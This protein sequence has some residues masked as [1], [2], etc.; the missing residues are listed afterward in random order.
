[1]PFIHSRK[2]QSA[3]D[4]FPVGSIATASNGA[5]VR[6]VGHTLEDDVCFTAVV[7]LDP[8]MA[9][10]PNSRISGTEESPIHE[11]STFTRRAV[12]MNSD[13]W[14]ESTWVVCPGLSK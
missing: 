3:H 10:S 12:G 9:P 8:T 13:Y 11:H 5:L 14:D 2:L 7:Y 6:I 1:M 4:T